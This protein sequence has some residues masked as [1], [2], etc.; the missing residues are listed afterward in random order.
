MMYSH[1][2][3]KSHSGIFPFP[4]YRC[5]MEGPRGLGTTIGNCVGGLEVRDSPGRAVSPRSSLPCL[6]A[7]GDAIVALHHYN[8]VMVALGLGRGT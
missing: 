6:R 1:K 3:R 4:G 7:A 8:G 2:A 5:L